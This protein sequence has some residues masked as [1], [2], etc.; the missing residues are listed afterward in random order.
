[1]SFLVSTWAESYSSSFVDSL[2][3][4][5]R[6]LEASQECVDDTA[7]L[8]NDTALEERANQLANDWTALTESCASEFNRTTADARS[9]LSCNVDS[10]DL[11][12]NPAYRAACSANGVLYEVDFQV[13]CEYDY[14][15]VVDIYT[16]T[17]TGIPFCLAEACDCDDIKSEAVDQLNVYLDIWADAQ[18]DSFTNVECGTITTIKDTDGNEICQKDGVA[19]RSLWFLTLVAVAIGSYFFM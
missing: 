12:A 8:F 2:S 14:G 18:D 13:R 4:T 17:L 1:M 7:Q 15:L 3:S 11:N 16:W 9:A 19:E 10:G 5:S 6:H